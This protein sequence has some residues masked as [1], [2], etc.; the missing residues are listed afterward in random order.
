M[1]IPSNPPRLTNILGYGADISTIPATTPSGSGAFSYQSGFPA[2]TAIPLTAGG[3]AP[4]REDFNAVIKLMSQ[5]LFFLQSGSLYTWNNTLDYL[6]GAHI[7]GSNGQEYVAV[8]SS[9]PDTSAKAQNPVKDTKGTYWKAANQGGSSAGEVPIGGILPFSGTF[10]GSGNRFPIPLG[11]SAPL[12]NWCLC[13]GTTTGGKPVPDLRNRMI[14]CAGTTYKTGS[15]GG[16]AT[17]THSVSGTVG[18]TTLTEAQLA[19][20][21][22]TQSTEG[23]DMKGDLALSQRAWQAP[24][25]HTKYGGAT[26]N[27]GSSASHAHSLSG[28]K[29]GAASSLPPFYVPAYIAF[30]FLA[31]SQKKPPAETGGFPYI[32]T[33]ASSAGAG[34]CCRPAQGRPCRAAR[35]L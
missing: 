6:P 32:F 11:A 14:M 30:L 23:D 22:H 16:A 28:V 4:S 3:I 35:G 7:L 21:K 27:S 9:G 18:A 10:G 12:T 34:C 33:A 20:H 26:Y 31:R 5:H 19:A 24:V 17:H 29:S 1:P 15:K 13:D 2:I 8:Q 25:L